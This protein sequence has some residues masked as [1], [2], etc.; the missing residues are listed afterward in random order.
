VDEEAADFR[1]VEFEGVFERGDDLVDLRHRQV[2]GQSAVAVDLDA[3]LNA[4][5][6][7]V[8][9]VENL[10]EGLRGAAEADFKLTVA[11]KGDGTL[12]GGGF[13]FDVSED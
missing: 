3:I 5:D 1:A 11:L 8:V 12:D 9:D 6:E 13:A 4:G 7:N 2:V 10:R